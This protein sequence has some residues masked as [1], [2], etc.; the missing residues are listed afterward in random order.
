MK[1]VVPSPQMCTQGELLG[2]L[3]P[4]LVRRLSLFVC[5]GLIHVKR[6]LLVLPRPLQLWLLAANITFTVK[7]APEFHKNCQGNWLS[8]WGNCES[9]ILTLHGR[10]IETMRTAF[11]EGGQMHAGQ[12]GSRPQL[13]HRR[14]SLLRLAGQLQGGHAKPQGFGTP[15]GTGKQSDAGFSHSPLSVS[16]EVHLLGS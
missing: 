9:E 6:S 15:G 16:A 8:P 10:D 1:P 2:H 11:W 13:G 3:T 14:G 4:V 7:K 5:T 12:L